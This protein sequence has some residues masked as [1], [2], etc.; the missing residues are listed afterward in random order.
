[1]FKNNCANTLEA[2][3][4]RGQCATRKAFQPATFEEG[5]HQISVLIL[6]NTL[7]LGSASISVSCIVLIFKLIF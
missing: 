1:M 7:I 3:T 6:R 4:L 5:G 2:A